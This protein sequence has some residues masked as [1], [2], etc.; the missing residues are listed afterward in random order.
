MTKQVHNRHSSGV[1][2]ALSIALLV[3]PGIA[4]LNFAASHKPTLSNVFANG[5]DVLTPST[6]HLVHAF[7]L[8]MLIGGLLVAA[9]F[10]VRLTG[11]R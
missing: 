6:Y 1:G 10:A 5:G 11:R 7:A 4:A 2:L 9:T 8:L 3:V